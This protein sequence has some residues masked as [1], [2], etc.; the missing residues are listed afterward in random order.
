MFI[1]IIIK[2]IFLTNIYNIV[3][4]LTN[5]I[6]LN[7]DHHLYDIICCIQIKHKRVEIK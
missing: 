1:Y 5:A 4:Y 2:Y 7:T 6:S 3:K